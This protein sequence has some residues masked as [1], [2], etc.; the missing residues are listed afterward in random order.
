MGNVVEGGLV[1]CN[2]TEEFDVALDNAMK[3][4]KSLHENGAKFCSY[5]VKEKADVIRN[6]CTFVP[7]VD[8][9]SH[10]KFTLRTPVNV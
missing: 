9:V 2:S 7:C 6:C 1:D 4:W 8:W 5:F 10:Q 3:N